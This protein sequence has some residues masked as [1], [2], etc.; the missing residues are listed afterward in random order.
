MYLNN[1]ATGLRD[2]YRRSHSPADLE[3]A[4]A[5]HQ[6]VV[7][8]TPAD[9]PDRPGYLSNLGNV[10]RARYLLD[11]DAADLE[12]AI[13][14]YR[15]AC[16]LGLTLAPAVTLSTAQTWGLQAGEREA[17]DEAVEAYADGLAA[18]DQ[19]YAT[20]LMPGAK[21][22]WL[23]DAQGVAAAAAYAMAKT[24]DSVRCL[25]RPRAWSSPPVDRGDPA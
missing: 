24:G 1:L 6:E 2:R 19:L 16:K 11:G 25:P 4:I 14:A 3:A 15:Q 8:T 20:Q 12:A 13:D 17:W 21:Q 18:I 9:A 5:A 22:A 10:L 7:E 23:R